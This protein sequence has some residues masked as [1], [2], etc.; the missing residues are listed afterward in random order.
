QVLVCAA[1]ASGMLTG[2]FGIWEDPPSDLSG[3]ERLD[4]VDRQLAPLVPF[5]RAGWIEVQHHPDTDSD[6]F[7]VIPLGGLCSALAD[8]IVRYE[9]DDWGVGIGCTFTYAG[10]AIWRSG[11]SRAWSSRLNVH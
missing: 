3:T 11:W 5:V 9:G 7:T 8:P 6:A 1:E 4:W 10:L 2:P